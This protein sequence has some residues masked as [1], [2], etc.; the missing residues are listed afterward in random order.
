MVFN[1]YKLFKRSERYVQSI[2]FSESL[3]EITIIVKDGEILHISNCFENVRIKLVERFFGFNR[4]G[5]NFKLQIDV[6]KNGKFENVI[7]Q[8]EIGG[9]SLKL[10]KEIIAIYSE[11]KKV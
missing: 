10:F 7:E 11:V 3:I 8:Y 9:W 5:R 4:I 1:I 6:M 2:I